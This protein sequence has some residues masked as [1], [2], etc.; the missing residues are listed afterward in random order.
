M[1]CCNSDILADEVCCL[2]ERNFSCRC[3]VGKF[4]GCL[5]NPRAVTALAK[6]GRGGKM[7]I[8]IKHLE[9]L[10]SLEAF[11]GCASLLGKYF[12]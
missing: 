1:F 10:H 9:L 12:I 8:A 7:H 2:N 3:R 6:M 11:E 4:Y 5:S